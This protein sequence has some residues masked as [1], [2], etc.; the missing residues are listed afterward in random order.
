MRPMKLWLGG[1]IAVVG[2]GSALAADF[3]DYALRGSTAQPVHYE[4]PAQPR[5]VPGYPVRPRWDGVY[6]GGQVGFANS[7]VNFSGGVA[8]LVANLLRETTVQAEF[9]PSDWVN[10]P[11]QSITRPSYGGFIGYNMQRDEILFGI[12]ANYN[13]TNIRMGAGDSIGRVVTTSDGYANTVVLSGASSMHLTDYGTLRARAGW[14]HD[15][16][17][18]YGFG[19]VAVARATVSRMASVTVDGVDADPACDNPPDSVCLP[20]YTFAAS[21]GE[22]KKGAFAYGWTLGAG[23]DWFVSSNLFVRGEYEYIG[24]AKFYGVDFHIH[25]ARAAAGIR[26]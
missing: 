13:R 12:E 2:A 14:V 26:F 11:N 18:P 5:F 6:I 3:K 23:V 15:S 7:G 4:V 1:V 9:S 20:S 24:F 25:T 10:L 17:I 21:E 16:L 19:G 22:T 8:D